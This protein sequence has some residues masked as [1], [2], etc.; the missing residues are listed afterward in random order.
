M[1]TSGNVQDRALEEFK[2]GPR[3]KDTKGIKE[4]FLLKL[5][6]MD[7]YW[8][9]PLDA[10][11]RCDIAF[12]AVY[13]VF[14]MAPSAIWD[15]YL[16]RFRQTIQR[17]IKGDQTAEMVGQ[18]HEISIDDIAFKI[19]NHVPDWDG[20]KDLELLLKVAVLL[21]DIISVLELAAVIRRMKPQKDASLRAEERSAISKQIDDLTRDCVDNLDDRIKPKEKSFVDFCSS[22]GFCFPVTARSLKRKLSYLVQEQEQ[23]GGIT[24]KF[25][26]AHAGLLAI[27]RREFRSSEG[28]VA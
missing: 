3:A 24:K 1:E 19:P 2:R 4:A 28:F 23:L 17:V 18:I 12:S 20:V 16:H 14:D 22:W 7:E 11:Q 13:G 10:E 25:K 8:A 6:A 27:A 15:E 5:F 21:E 26:K 9:I